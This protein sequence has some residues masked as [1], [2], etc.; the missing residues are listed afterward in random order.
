MKV[1]IVGTGY[2][3][4]VTGAGFADVGVDVTCIDINEEKI[5]LL[6]DGKVPFYEPGLE[7]LLRRN[8]E[9]NRL[10]FSTNLEE[11]VK[12][13]DAVFLAV[14]TPMAENGAADLSYIFAAAKQVAE[15]A[16]DSLVLVTKST[17]PVGTAE[18]VRAIV[19]KHGA[20]SISVASNPRF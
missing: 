2:V 19:D 3:G 15:A 8:I 5:K 16:T 10:Q 13:V 11:S 4:L 12:G 17:V 6:L 18:Q 1:A 9:K 20:H 7:D 14:G